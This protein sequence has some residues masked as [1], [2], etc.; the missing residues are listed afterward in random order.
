MRAFLLSI[1]LL[2]VSCVSAPFIG[3]LS[4]QAG[5]RAAHRDIASGRMKIYRAGTRAS[6]EVGVEPADRAFVAQLPRDSTLPIG[7]TVP[8]ASEAVDFARAY[9]R[10]IVIH[11]RTHPST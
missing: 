5:E 3:S 4:P 11:F 2:T 9:N 1:A 7:C 8:H 10:Q 6:S